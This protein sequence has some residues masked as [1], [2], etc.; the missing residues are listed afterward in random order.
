MWAISDIPSTSLAIPS[1]SFSIRDCECFGY[2]FDHQP[3]KKLLVVLSSPPG[4]PVPEKKKKQLLAQN[5]QGTCIVMAG[6]LA[7]LTGPTSMGDGS[8]LVPQLMLTIRTFPD[9]IASRSPRIRKE[10]GAPRRASDAEVY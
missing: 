7:T 4:G 3:Q 5:G 10:T 9:S 8:A 2:A 1:V 6:Y